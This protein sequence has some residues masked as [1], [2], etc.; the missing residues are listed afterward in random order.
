MKRLLPAFCLLLSLAAPAQEKNNFILYDSELH[1]FLQ[2]STRDSIS[3]WHEFMHLYN[4]IK[5]EKAFTDRQRDSIQ[6]ANYRHRVKE[7]LQY[8]WS[9]HCVSIDT[10]Q[11]RTKLF[12]SYSED[13]VVTV[14]AKI[15]ID[16]DIP[17]IK[18]H[19]ELFFTGYVPPNNSVEYINA[20]SSRDEELQR[21]FSL[22]YEPCCDIY[23][24]VIYSRPFDY[25]CDVNSPD[26]YFYF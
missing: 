11:K 22:R 9:Y 25:R 19:Q 24:L 1:S 8:T 7:P 14:M 6:H 3:I 12:C 13:T 2:K 18:K 16:I 10:S 5:I 15:R 17:A 26:M 4:V 23:V 21:Y 20:W